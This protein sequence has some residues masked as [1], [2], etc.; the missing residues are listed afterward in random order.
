VAKSGAAVVICPTTEANLGDGLCD[1]TG[2]LAAGVPI[3][4][5]SDSHVTRDALE[6]LRWLDYGQRLALRR[7][8]VAAAPQAGTTSTAERLFNLTT[9]AGAAAAGEPAWGLQ[10]GARAD[11]LVADTGDAPLLGLPPDRTLDALVFSSPGK[12]WRDVLVAGRWVISGHQHAAHDRIARRFE[13]AMQT[14]WTAG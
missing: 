3:T 11:A 13:A 12:P 14:L 5:G 1:L 8:N 4:I 7:R 6:E 10:S 9:D 2:W